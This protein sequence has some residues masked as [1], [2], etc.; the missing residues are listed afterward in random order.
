[1]PLLEAGASASWLSLCDGETEGGVLSRRYT[2]PAGT[3]QTLRLDVERVTGCSQVPLAAEPDA[4]RWIGLVPGATARRLDAGLG[5]VGEFDDRLATVSEVAVTQPAVDLPAGGPQAGPVAASQADDLPD[6]DPSRSTWLWRVDD[7]LR[8]LDGLIDKLTVAGIRTVFLALPIDREPVAVAQAQELGQAIGRLRRAG[9]EVWAVEGDPAAVTLSGQ[10]PFLAR[11]RALAR[12]NAA[13]PAGQRIAGIQYDI[14]PYLNPHFAL[15]NTV[16]L[17]AYVDTV[18]RL[19]AAA[20]MP[21][22]LAVPFWWPALSLDGE[23]L[24]AALTDHAD[25]LAVMNYRTD[26]QQIRELARPFLVWGA[27]HGRHVRI[28]LE[29]GPLPDQ[30]TRHFRAGSPGRLWHIRLGDADALVLLDQALP[31]P[32]GVSL[33]Q[34]YSVPAPAANTT[35]FGQRDQLQALIPELEES[36]QSR[37]AFAGI[38]LHEYVD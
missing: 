11:T 19:K 21:V 38:A 2:D 22:E 34:R 17:R 36:W 33:Q 20:K 13:L 6:R 37:P 8:N 3:S 27:V 15:D 16:W 23:P 29:A 28:G 35:F 7:V 24:L 30:E 14:E 10:G 5:L 9:I 25:G 1:M 4:V 12:F 31:N 18:A 26:P 32:A